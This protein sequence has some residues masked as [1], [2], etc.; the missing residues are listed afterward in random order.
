[1]KLPSTPVILAA[2]GVITALAHAA[3]ALFPPSSRVHW[4]ADK[5][6]ALLPNVYDLLGVGPDAPPSGLPTDATYQQ[7]LAFQQTPQ[8]QAI[9]QQLLA[10]TIKKE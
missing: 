3:Q 1:M 9:R 7:A 2:L 5:L 6:L 4:A 8:Q 10:Q